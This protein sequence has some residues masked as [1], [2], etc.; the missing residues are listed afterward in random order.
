MEKNR[1]ISATLTALPDGLIKDCII[2]VNTNGE[3]ISIE[4]E[5]SDLDSRAGVERYNGLLLP[6]MVNCHCHLEYSY[7]KGMISRNG[8][9]PKF[10][11]T[12]IDIK[13]NRPIEEDFKFEMAVAADKAMFENGIQ[14]VGDHSNYEYPTPIKS[15]SPIYYH[16]FLEMLEE[17]GVPAVDSFKVG[18]ERIGLQK[19]AGVVSTVSP[20]ATYTLN[21]EF[22]NMIGSEDNKGILSI[23]FK[24][25]V[26]LG[27]EDERPRVF[28]A[29]SPNRDGLLLIHSI[30]ASS[31][32]IDAAVERY[33]DKVTVVPCPLSNIYIEERLPDLDM[34]RNKGIRIALG[35]D[36]L[37]SNDILSILEEIKCVSKNYPNY[38]LIDI[39]NWATIN[40]AIA[41]GISDWAGSI[42]VGKRPGL[43]LAEGVDFA[44]EKLTDDATPKRLV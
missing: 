6:G 40:G 30:Y 42:E 31:D 33:G 35:T 11:E 18:V 7:V 20:H 39:I 3:I 38:P 27:G 21:D 23:H 12:I 41:L 26:V 22:I 15:A 4:R 36:G 16:S 44:N 34:F 5:V 32:D 1:K 17:E 13:F 43:V 2:E 25:S 9:L 8:G 37:S 24:E 10:I 19:S 28:N 29:I 14:A